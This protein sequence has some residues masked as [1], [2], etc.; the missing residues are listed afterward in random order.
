MRVFNEKLICEI[1]LRSGI[2]YLSINFLLKY[3]MEKVKAAKVILPN[4]IKGGFEL[5][6]DSW[7]ILKEK[8]KKLI[9]PLLI[10]P[11]ILMLL[12]IALGA[13]STSAVYMFKVAPLAFSL[14]I[15][16][17]ILLSAFSVFIVLAIVYLSVVINASVI[18]LVAEEIG[19]KDAFKKG[20]KIFWKYLVW[21]ILFGIMIVIAFILFFVPGIILLVFLSFSLFALTLENSGLVASFKR[22]IQLV[23]GFWWTVFARFLVLSIIV[24]I[25][26]IISNLLTDSATE[27]FKISGKEIYS[28]IP[29]IILGI[30]IYIVSFIINFFIS[31]ISL[32]YNFLLYKRVKEIKDSNAESKDSMPTSRKIGL[33]ILIGVIFIITIAT[34]I[35]VIVWSLMSQLNMNNSGVQPQAISAEM[36][37]Q[38]NEQIQAQIENNK[39]Q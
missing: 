6:S 31:A 1:S 23:K 2:L 35:L 25:V 32:I 39:Q 21:A 11:L 24:I 15:T 27:L 28:I 7:K 34:V 14:K 22:S 16:L 37:A 38:I 3:S 8:W 19:I 36:Q 29:M 9:W 20:Q 30:L 4:S 13:S 18:Y 5:L 17:G 10:F 33:G 12:T 26:S